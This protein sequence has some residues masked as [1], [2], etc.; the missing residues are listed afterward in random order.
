MRSGSSRTRPAVFGSDCLGNVIF[1][2]HECYHFTE[3]TEFFSPIF[4]VRPLAL[5][6]DSL[7]IIV[8][9]SVARRLPCAAAQPRS[10]PAANSVDNCPEDRIASRLSIEYEKKS[11]SSASFKFPPLGPAHG[12][13]RALIGV[14]HRPGRGQRRG[15]ARARGAGSGRRSEGAGR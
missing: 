8:I 13:C 12:K 5:C 7:G 15:A 2:M 3:S 6:P 9:M 11:A 10:T 4:A 1:R 14:E